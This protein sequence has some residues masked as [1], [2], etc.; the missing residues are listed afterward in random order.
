MTS[1]SF[2]PNTK[3]AYTLLGPSHQGA[4]F[5]AILHRQATGVKGKR[6][7]SVNAGDPGL[8]VGGGTINLEF[9]TE[10]P[11]PSAYKLQHAKALLHARHGH[12]INTN[13][14]ANAPMQL[15][16]TKIGDGDIGRGSPVSGTT[17]LDVFSQNAWPKNLCENYA[18]A[19]TIPPYGPS[20]DTDTGFLDAVKAT[21][22]N[23]AAL[24]ENYNQHLDTNLKASLPTLETITD[25][26]VCLLSGGQFRRPTTT[27][28]QVAQ[29]IFD[30]LSDIISKGNSGLE[31]VEFESGNGEF[32]GLKS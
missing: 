1:P 3:T 6:M 11:N 4:R 2:F 20:Y 15:I 12:L 22:S 23:I 14:P 13:Y 24:I 8:Y 29:S 19:Y 16:M 28:D 25:L 10:I 27:V 9:S 21:A 32:S 7:A 26:R 30:G 5:S 17:F 18:M 31:L